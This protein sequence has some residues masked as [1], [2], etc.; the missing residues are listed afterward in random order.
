MQDF[1][2]YF[3]KIVALDQSAG[4]GTDGPLGAKKIPGGNCP[5]APVFPAPMHSGICAKKLF[6]D[7]NHKKYLLDKMKKSVIFSRIRKLIRWLS[8]VC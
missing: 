1:S 6:S 4:G 3:V 8:I 5:P 7:Q 2:N